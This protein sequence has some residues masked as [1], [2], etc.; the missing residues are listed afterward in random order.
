MD[1]FEYVMVL[2]S[3][4]VGLALT[5]LLQGLVEIAQRPKRMKIASIHLVWVI[6]MVITVAFW[7][8]WQFKLQ[9]L[10]V[11]TFSAY[12]FVLGYAVI[13]YIL[14]TLLFPRVLDPDLDLD[15]FFYDR[16]GWFFGFNALYFVVDMIDSRLKGEYVVTTAL[17]AVLCLGAMRTRNPAYHWAVGLA[18]L[19]YQTNWAFRQFGTMG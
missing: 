17:S 19:L 18:I 12:L 3:I 5:H 14:S 13:L 8:W 6:Y 11:W 10:P 9:Q 7:W 15:D 1:M 2:V 4:I 16:R